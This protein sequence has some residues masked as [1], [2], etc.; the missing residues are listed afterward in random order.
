MTGIKH[1]KFGTLPHGI[2]GFDVEFTGEDIDVV[3]IGMVIYKVNTKYKNVLLHGTYPDDALMFTLCASL[4]ARGYT[5]AVVID[6]KVY[7]PWLKN[8]RLVIAELNPE[9]WP[10]FEVD[11]VWY[12]LKDLADPE[13]TLPENVPALYVLPQKPIKPAEVE[14]W[15]ENAEHFWIVV[16]Y[17]MERTLWNG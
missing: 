16:N 7:Y 13:P 3:D 8:V 1:I 17:K 12:R 4:K 14:T 15:L 5:T 11:Q 10:A 6:G 9:P 2:V